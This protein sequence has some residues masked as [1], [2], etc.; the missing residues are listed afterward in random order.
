LLRALEGDVV[1]APRLLRGRL[2]EPVPNPAVP[3]R[4]TFWPSQ[5]L[6]EDGRPV[7]TP[8]RFLSSGDLLGIANADALLLLRAGTAVPS[9]GDEIFFLSLAP[10]FAN[11]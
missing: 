6:L 9:P 7:L 2:K 4:D 11:A 5:R 8:C 3:R 1:T 10:E